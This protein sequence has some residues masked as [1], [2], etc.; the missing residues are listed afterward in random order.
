MSVASIAKTNE[1]TICS[2]PY[3]ALHC[4]ECGT[5]NCTS[6]GVTKKSLGEKKE[7]CSKEKNRSPEEGG[8]GAA[9]DDVPKGT[10]PRTK[11]PG[12]PV[13]E[14]KK[15]VAKGAS[16]SHKKQNQRENASPKRG[17]KKQR[18]PTKVK[19]SAPS[20]VGDGDRKAQSPTKKGTKKRKS[21]ETPSSPS[22]PSTPPG[23]RSQGV[24]YQRFEA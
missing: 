1:R 3:C 7:A 16:K 19:V 24:M 10:A 13:V 18:K 9:A 22:S 5:T 20:I 14:V 4:S 11:I 23:V 15:T 2:S 17:S 21:P 12:A 8:H 6:V